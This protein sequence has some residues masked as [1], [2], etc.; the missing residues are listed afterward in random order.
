M[1]A[2]ISS[3]LVP[4]RP[5]E[6]ARYTIREL[7]ILG[8]TLPI[9][10]CPINKFGPDALGL[11]IISLERINESLIQYEREQMR[12]CYIAQHQARKRSYEAAKAKVRQD[13]NERGKVCLPQSS[14]I[15]LILDW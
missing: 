5:K 9:R 1:S 12:Q 6:Q 10:F 8:L 2:F 15:T 11:E 14:R 4:S 3:N 7:L 13:E